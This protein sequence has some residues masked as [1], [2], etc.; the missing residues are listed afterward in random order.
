MNE[1][2]KTTIYLLESVDL[3]RQSGVLKMRPSQPKNAPWITLNVS[4]SPLLKWK[5]ENDDRKG[6]KRTDDW[7]GTRFESTNTSPEYWENPFSLIKFQ[8]KGKSDIPV[9]Y[10]LDLVDI[11]KGFKQ[12]VADAFGNKEER[13][14]NRYISPKKYLRFR[15]IPT[16]DMMKDLDPKVVLVEP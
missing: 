4:L 16:E 5:I 14:V 3:E 15:E 9:N 7:V 6:L 2:A 10:R 8:P 11:A 13:F 1:N 12:E